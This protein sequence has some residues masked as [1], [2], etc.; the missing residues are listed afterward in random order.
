MDVVGWHE[1][2]RA[3][4]S[5]AETRCRLLRHVRGQQ[6]FSPRMAGFIGAG[7]KLHSLL[8]LDKIVPTDA[9]I[10]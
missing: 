9:G 2:G 5:S 3:I 8:G 1:I 7:F 10:T 4:F 6:F